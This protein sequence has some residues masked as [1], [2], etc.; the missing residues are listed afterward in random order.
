VRIGGRVLRNAG[1]VLGLTAVSQEALGQMPA[2]DSIEAAAEAAAK[3]TIQ[4]RVNG[5][6]VKEATVGSGEVL[7]DLT[8]VAV[9]EGDDAK[10]LLRSRGIRP[11]GHAIA[12]FYLLNPGIRDADV[13]VVGSSVIVPK[14]A[15]AQDDA[16]SSMGRVTYAVIADTSYK[17]TVPERAAR[18]AELTDSLRSITT[19]RS[20]GRALQ[21]TSQAITN[22]AHVLTQSANPLPEGAGADLERSL[23]AYE[24]QITEAIESGGQ[25]PDS[26]RRAGRYAAAQVR[27][28]ATASVAGRNHVARLD[29]N[30]VDTQGNDRSNVKIGYIR[31]LWEADRSRAGFVVKLAP[32]KIGEDMDLGYWTLWV[33]DL[34]ARV[35]SIERRTVELTALRSQREVTL[36]AR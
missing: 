33:E 15:L 18:I 19:S 16:I 31:P 24:K 7:L 36:I 35:I 32:G 20:Q 17:I 30:V 21:A 26:L 4:I 23:D 27:Q 3:T 28:H 13:L 9:R 14:P 25:V 11:D 6:P 2:P 29:F 8:R 12:L 10:S 34:T 1:L 22:S 5:Q